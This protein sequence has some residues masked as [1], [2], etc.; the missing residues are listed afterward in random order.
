MMRIAKL[1][2]IPLLVSTLAHGSVATTPYPVPEQK[3]TECVSTA[4]VTYG[5]PELVIRA[6]LKQEAGLVGTMSRNSNGSYD[7]GPMQINTINLGLISK[8]YPFLDWR[9]IT[10]NPC[11]NIMVGTWFLQQKIQNRGGVIWEG[12]GDYHSVT[13][14]KRSVYLR[15]FLAHYNQLKKLYGL[16]PLRRPAT[17]AKQEAIVD[18]QL[19][20]AQASVN[21]PLMLSRDLPPRYIPD[22]LSLVSSFAMLRRSEQK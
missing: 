16:K 6:I 13:P 2:A 19:R 11:I 3:L 4:S 15:S 1:A 22:N 12:V 10:Y 9:H 20:T 7:L 17:P 21:P 18:T 5:V 14:S 8:K